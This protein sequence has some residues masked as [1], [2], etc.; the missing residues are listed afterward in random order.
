MTGPT[1]RQVSLDAATAALLGAFAD[2]LIPPGGGFPAPSEARIVEDFICRY[3]AAESAE[4]VYPPAVTE[5]DLATLGAALGAGFAGA[6]AAQRTDTVAV[7]EAERPEL[8]GRL[9]MLVYAGYYSR[10]PVRAA[11]ASE[12]E[13]GR[14]YRGAP[15]P[16]GYDDVIEDWDESLLSDVGGYRATDEVGPVDR[17]ALARLVESFGE[18]GSGA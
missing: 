18:G 6:A 12:L 4:T 14:D 17:G 3:V 16:Y 1:P 7:L 8:F 5:G 11:I 15:L 9:R 10:P 13:A 2:T